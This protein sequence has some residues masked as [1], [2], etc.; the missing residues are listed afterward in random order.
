[1]VKSAYVK[2]IV[3]RVSNTVI[4]PLRA[5]K[6]PANFSELCENHW[7]GTLSLSHTGS[8]SFMGRVGPTTF[9]T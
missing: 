1:M 2:P 5:T 3:T 8:D 4:A 9:C 6:T 7:N